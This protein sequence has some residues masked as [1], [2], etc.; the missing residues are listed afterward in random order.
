M[1][2]ELRCA[3][4]KIVGESP[5]WLFSHSDMEAD[6]WG[7]PQTVGFLPTRDHSFKLDSRVLR[8]DTPNRELL[9]TVGHLFLGNI[10]V[11]VQISCICEFLSVM[12]QFLIA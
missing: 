11:S 10:H 7:L 8:L 6:G 2:L 1:F 4:L 3:A 9:Y 5:R 12:R